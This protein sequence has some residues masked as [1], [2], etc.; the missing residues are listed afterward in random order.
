ME[1]W[2]V[3]NDWSDEAPIVGYSGITV[4]ERAC[5]AG[6]CYQPAKNGGHV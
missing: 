3:S 5:S 2:P 1:P 6:R 4:A